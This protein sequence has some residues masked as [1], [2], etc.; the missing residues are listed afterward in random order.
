VFQRIVVG[1]SKADT[2]QVAARH[3]HDLAV[4][5][6]A[7]LHL[8]SATQPAPG[9][10]ADVT[11]RHSQALLESVAAGAGVATQIHVFPGDPAEALVTVCADVAADLVVVGN[12]GMQGK[13]HR[14]GSVPNDVAHR[15]PCSVLIVDSS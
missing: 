10:S 2:A 13:G 9:E 1:I 8:V 5:F 4:P 14:L 11:R 7:E 12:V 3:A 15:A 6:Q